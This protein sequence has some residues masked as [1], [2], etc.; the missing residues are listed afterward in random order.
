MSTPVSDERLLE[1]YH[2]PKVP[3]SLRGVAGLQT[4]AR[5]EGR[6]LTAEKATEILQGDRAY[7]VHGRVHKK[8]PNYTER[9]IVSSAYDLWEADLLDPARVRGQWSRKAYLLTVIDDFTRFAMVRVIPNK[10]AKTVGDALLDILAE[11][12]PANVRLNALRTDAGT[13]FFNA[14][15]REKVYKPNGIKHYRAQKGTGAAMAERFNRTL[16][17]AMAKWSTHKLHITDAQMTRAVPDF[18]HAY[19]NMKHSATRRK[20][21]EMQDKAYGRGNEADP[22]RRLRKAAKGDGLSDDDDGVAPGVE[23]SLNRMYQSTAMGRNKAPDPTDPTELG[24]KPDVPLHPGEAV[25][26]QKWNNIFHRGSRTGAF[27]D[28]VYKVHERHPFH[29]NAYIIKDE[30][31]EILK[32]KFQ[33]RL[34]Q[35]LSKEPDTWEVVVIR[36]G[37]G[38]KKGQLYVE[39]VG[40]RGRR[41]WIPATS[42][43]NN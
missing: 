1:L 25:R 28:E 14:Y 23:S 17:T 21:Q 12:L 38:K 42:I 33:R 13:E 7:T 18:V 10:A 19:N 8:E 9:I 37:T 30:K 36:R 32:G 6:S 39:W 24:E 35:R 16:T 40:H 2:T 41:E 15:C 5:A 3:G 20:P 43:Q 31:G 29:A 26:V 27:S 22:L 11:N 34:L 4:I